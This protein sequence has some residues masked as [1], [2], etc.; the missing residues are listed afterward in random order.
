MDEAFAILLETAA[1]GSF[2]VGA[3]AV[4]VSGGMREFEGRTVEIRRVS[5][6]LMLVRAT[7]DAPAMPQQIESRA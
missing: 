6:D 2:V 4:Q 7:G 3:G 1:D 5:L